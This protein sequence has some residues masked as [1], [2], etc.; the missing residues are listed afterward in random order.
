MLSPIQSQ[1]KPHSSPSLFLFLLL[2][3]L[4]LLLFAQGETELLMI[5]YV[6]LNSC[7]D[8]RCNPPHSVPCLL[9]LL[10]SVTNSLKHR[11]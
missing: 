7:W 3:L 9:G 8:S 2:L 1:P 6:I 10:V 11:I 4:L 5:L